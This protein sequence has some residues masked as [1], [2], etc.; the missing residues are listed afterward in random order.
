[1]ERDISTQLDAVI[2][3]GAVSI[4]TKGGPATMPELSQEQPKAGLSED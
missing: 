4:E 2:D 1:M 3:L